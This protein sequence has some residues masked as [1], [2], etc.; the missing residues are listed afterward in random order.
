MHPALANGV[1]VAV[2]G[3]PWY[4]PGD[5][6]V[7]RDRQDVLVSHRLIAYR[8]LDGTLHY[9]TRADTAARADAPVPR[10]RVLGR[11]STRAYPVS[12]KARVRAV[13]R[14]LGYIARGAWAR[15]TRAA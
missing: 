13:R 10:E 11:V 2:H 6:L 8:L 5:V 14:G 4:V 12:P 15:L 3:A 9:V 1:T 7:F